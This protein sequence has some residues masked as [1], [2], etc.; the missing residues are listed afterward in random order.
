[1]SAPGSEEM[2]RRAAVRAAEWIQDDMVVG[3]GT[4]STV[5]HLLDEIARRRS[6]GEWGRIIGI[7]TSEDTARKARD[8]GIPLGTLDD[9]PEIDLTVDGA[10]EVDPALDLIK[11]LGGALMREKIVAA[12]SREVVIVV[13]RSKR[14]QQLGTR[15]PLP[16]EVEPFGASLHESFFRALGAEPALRPASDGQPYRTDGGNLIWDCRFKSGIGNAGEL[17]QRLNARPGILES[18]LFVGLATR[19]VVAGDR[20]VEVLERRSGDRA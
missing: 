7:P 9:H 19:V 14:V 17:Q 10:D 13:D 1:M 4:G 15:A 11:G 18:G 5:R 16:V 3:L 12:A 20:D 6:A 8:L 2:K